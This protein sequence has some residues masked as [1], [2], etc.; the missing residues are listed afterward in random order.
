MNLNPRKRRVRIVPRSPRFPCLEFSFSR[1][2]VY[3]PG[4]SILRRRFDLCLAVPVVAAAAPCLAAPAPFP[5]NAQPLVTLHVATNGH[6]TVGN[7]SLE[8]PFRTLSRAAQDLAP[9]TEIRLQPGVHA[10][11]AF[12]Y[13]AQGTAEF[14]IWIRGADPENRP[15]LSGGSE[16]LHL[17]RPR[18][19]CV[20]NLEMHGAAFNGINCDDGGDVSDPNAAGMLLFRNLFLH[21]IGGSGNQDG[22]KLSG[23]RN[24]S[25]RDTE[26]V[27]CGGAGS[28]SGID[29]VGCHHGLIQGGHFS[30]F[31]GN[32]IQIKGGSTD[33]ELRQSVI[34]NAG[35]RGVNIG[36]S[37]GFE[38]FRP[39]LSETVPN[40]EAADI[41]IFANLFIGSTTTVAFVGS[42]DCVVANNTIIEPARWVF[43]VLQETTSS[44]PYIFRPCAEGAFLN[45]LI[46]YNHAQLARYVNE[47]PG[48]DPASFSV[49]NN[50]WF[51][52]D[53]PG[54]TPWPLPGSAM[55][56]RFGQDPLF[57]NG[58]AAD[59]R[60]T[61]LS[62][63]ATNGVFVADIH[64]DFVGQPNLNPPSIGAHELSGDTD[65][66]TLPDAWEIRYFGALT[67]TA[68]SDPDGDGFQNWEEYG[69]DTDPTNRASRLVLLGI[70]AT[71]PA[72]RLVWQ[73][74][75]RAMQFVEHS[76][77]NGQ[78]WG[79]H[80][81]LLPPTSTTNEVTLP[82]APTTSMW[83]V[84]AVLPQ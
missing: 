67:E 12:L 68:A 2:T 33:I 83:R 39:P 82:E 49:H 36:G 21:D 9:G 45:N 3:G 15:V 48:T 13:N 74:G 46:Y 30:D 76:S 84:R 6:D 14:P 35:H 1:A 51:A 19:L 26:I 69:A 10:G 43:R 75:R 64:D 40:V 32:A 5:A 59:Y 63:A 20:E 17:V 23:I 53:Q 60:I 44:G 47:G 62:P 42:V 55:N 79:V 70:D 54:A 34:S 78:S 72:R 4:V 65:A 8:Q 31:T 41:R 25:V 7:G 16:G 38:F 66:D 80:T 24:F 73:G 61:V 37:T 18:Y 22:L 52:Y 50:L 58:A 27:R 81:M 57:L 29:M 77:D 56:N 28:G 71:E 11:G